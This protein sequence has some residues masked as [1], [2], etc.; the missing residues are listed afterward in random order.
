[1]YVGQLSW[2]KVE[3]L[4]TGNVKLHD[5]TLSHDELLNKVP[6][7]ND[8]DK[9]VIDTTGHDAEVHAFN[10]VYCAYVADSSW[11]VYNYIDKR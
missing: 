7:L 5:C 6:N 8:T 10:P 2:G 3:Y 11:K 9:L 1:M 4:N